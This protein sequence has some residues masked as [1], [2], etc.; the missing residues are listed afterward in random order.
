MGWFVRKKHHF[1]KEYNLL[2]KEFASL[3][4]IDPWYITIE[5]ELFSPFDVESKENL[6]AL[7]AR[8]SNMLHFLRENRPKLD[9]KEEPYLFLKN[10]SG[11]YGLG[12]M[13]V[14]KLE[15][16]DHLSYKARKKMKASK[17]AWES[18]KLSYKKASRP[19]FIVKIS[20]V[21]SL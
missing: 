13:S 15:Q 14:N 6:K 5:T 16:L 20:K 17:G 21:Q 12:V 7:K 2:A 4:K 10:N 11:T 9:N 3:L 1:F 19:L 18:L 8:S